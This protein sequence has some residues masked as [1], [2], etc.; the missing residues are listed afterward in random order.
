[1][2]KK[3]IQKITRNPDFISGIHNYCDRWCERCAFTQRCACFALE[4]EQFAAPEDKD[5]QNKQ[6]WDK[7]GEIFQVTYDMLTDLAKQKGFDL[8]AIEYETIEKKEQ[9][10][11]ETAQALDCSIMSKEYI[12]LVKKWFDASHSVFKEKAEEFKTMAA[13]GLSKSQVKKEFDDLSNVVDVIRWY[14]Y[15]IHVKIIRAVKGLIED[16]LEPEEDDY[17][18]DSDGSAKVALLGIDRS[19]SAWGKVLSYFP[20]Q[21]DELLKILVLLE[22]LRRKTEKEFPNARVFVRPGFDEA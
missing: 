7:L 21:E 4:Q 22:R 3:D 10:L 5:F 20:D 11:N 2:N 13:I 16:R 12:T 14:Q 19:I 9:E 1:M 18:K 8:D 6:F 17:P 15:Q